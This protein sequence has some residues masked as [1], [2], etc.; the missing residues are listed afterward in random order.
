MRGLAYLDTEMRMSFLIRW[1]TTTGFYGDRSRLDKYNRCLKT[2]LPIPRNPTVPKFR[3]ITQ[4]SRREAL[5]GATL[6]CLRQYGHEGIS[7]R[8]ISAEAGVSIGLINHHF[9]RKSSLI[10]ATYK[11]LALA[12]QESMRRLAD[13]KV[14]S[15][16]QQLSVFFRAS[17]APES[18]DPQLFNVWLVFWSMAAHSHEI[19]VVHDLTYA[20]YRS[21]LVTL[22]RRLSKSGA[23][24]NF[25]LRPAAIALSALLDGLW[26]EISLSPVTFKPSEAINMCEDWITAL[27]S[28][29]FPSLLNESLRAK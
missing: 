6:R 5:I 15:P 28:G 24:P 13:E 17:F 12:L 19:R 23:A 29:S 1:P 10:A 21:L 7:V 16:Q 9:P 20:S 11:T 14:A 8:R 25:K 3:R 4:A 26:L 27:C 18:I 2:Q 22:M